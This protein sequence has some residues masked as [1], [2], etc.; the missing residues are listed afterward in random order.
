MTTK[1]I[2]VTEDAYEA[3]KGM[4]EEGESFSEAIRRISGKRCLREFVGA[5]SSES[6]EKLK[7]SIAEL[8]HSH[9]LAHRARVTHIAS[10]LEG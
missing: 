9:T 4:K 3:L 5:I 1:T 8:R 2:T 6:A 7:K 10:A